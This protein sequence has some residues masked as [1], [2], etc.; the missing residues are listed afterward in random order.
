MVAQCAGCN[1]YEPWAGLLVGLMAGCV[2]YGISKLMVKC[3]LDDPLDAVAVHAGGGTLGVLS[4]PW[5]KRGKG[6]FW[7]ANV[8]FIEWSETDVYLNQTDDYVN[9]WKLL[10]VNVAG[11]VTI[12]A[13]SAFWS[14]FVFGGLQFFDNLRVDKNTETKGNDIVRFAFFYSKLV[15]T[16]TDT[17]LSEC[18]TSK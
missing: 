11:L 8:E 15:G 1:V 17:P 18:K 6:I 4:V 10:G 16:K 9:P 7:M 13:W 12:I 5:F 14:T 3:G 2:Y